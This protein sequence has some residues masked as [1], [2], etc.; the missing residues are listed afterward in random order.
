[1]ATQTPAQALTLQFDYRF[2]SANFFAD[3]SRQSV[4]NAAGTYFSSL[5][6]DSL[7]AITSSGQNLFTAEFLAPSTLQSTLIPNFSV[8][9]DTLVVFVGGNST[10][11]AGTLGQGGPGGYSAQGSPAFLNT[12]AMRGQS[13]PTTGQSATEF[14]P[15][16]GSVIFNSTAQWYFDS[17]VTTTEAFAG[18]DF[19]SVAL[20]ELGHLLGLGTADS[21][22]TLISNGVFT[23]AATVAAKGASVPVTADRGHWA[24]GTQGV[25]NGQPQETAMDPTLTVGSRKRF[26][27]VDVAALD[28]IGWQI[29]PTVSPRQVPLLHP[30]LALML[31]AL[32][33]GV[34]HR[35]QT[36]S[37]PKR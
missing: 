26:T 21:W 10:L 2:D 1:M 9:A 27:N 19:Y 4:L 15:W 23:G 13:A 24:E 18:S 30:F 8:A 11:G 28:D 36:R 6:T 25:V 34:A 33:S 7:T 3:P 31:G 14:A 32:L 22:F 17:D 29:A 16:G 5:L 35:R 20:H 37:W 12:V